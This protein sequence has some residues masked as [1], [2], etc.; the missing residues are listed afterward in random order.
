MVGATG[1]V[2]V[3]GT[4]AWPFLEGD[5]RRAV[6][7]A[8]MLV[9]GTQLPLHALLMRWRERNDRFLAAIVLGFGGRVAL[10][11][12]AVAYLVIPG[13]V[14]TAPFLVALAVFLFGVFVLET[15]LAF[16][17]ARSGRTAGGS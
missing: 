15:L 12:A 13:R 1:L 2:L 4:A 5:A 3:G 14:A 10:L 16:L 9:L 7:G 17:G 11:G 8:G 6:V